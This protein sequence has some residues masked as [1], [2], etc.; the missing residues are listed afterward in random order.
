[1]SNSAGLLFVN[2]IVFCPCLVLPK[3]ICSNSISAAFL[4]LNCTFY[5]LPSEVIGFVGC[6]VLAV[7]GLVNVGWP[8]LEEQ[9]KG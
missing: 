2:E 1:M 6:C 3:F 8:D 7:L 5:V 4:S 9:L